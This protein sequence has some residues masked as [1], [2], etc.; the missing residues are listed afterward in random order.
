MDSLWRH[1]G[2]TQSRPDIAVQLLFIILLSTI[3][4]FFTVNR[5]SPNPHQKTNELA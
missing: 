5:T 3:Q 2:F 4:L 1:Y